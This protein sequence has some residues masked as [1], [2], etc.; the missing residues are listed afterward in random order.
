MASVDGRVDL[1]QIKT[2]EEFMRFASQAITSITDVVNGRIEFLKNIQNNIVTV[3]FTTSNTDVAVKHNLNKTG[4]RYIVV[5]MTAAGTIYTGQT[6]ASPT[7]L[8][9][10]CNT[11]LTAELY[12]F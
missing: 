4:V 10:R 12:L 2:P 11:P 8:Y 3:K 6:T 5:S 7:T 9:L 1:S